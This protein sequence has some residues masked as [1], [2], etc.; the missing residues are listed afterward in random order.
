VRW[1]DA[2]HPFLR[3]NLRNR[4]CGLH[5]GV[6]KTFWV[7]LL[8]GIASFFRMTSLYVKNG[9]VPAREWRP[10]WVYK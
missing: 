1:T 8:V 4:C 3:G 2:I 10:C 6:V 9:I 5:N 7:F